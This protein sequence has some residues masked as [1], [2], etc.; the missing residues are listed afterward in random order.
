MLADLEMS[1]ASCPLPFSAFFGIGRWRCPTLPAAAATAPSASPSPGTPP[2]P[3][4]KRSTQIA[5]L[6]LE[7]LDALP[8]FLLCDPGVR[9]Q[10]FG[11]RAERVNPFGVPAPLRNARQQFGITR[12]Q[13][14]ELLAF[15]YLL[16]RH[17]RRLDDLFS[18][19]MRQLLERL[20]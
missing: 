18:L 16:D 11:L 19:G 8:H 2:P 12:A 7:R 10:R 17:R 6:R 14:C 20:G 9:V 5:N 15:Y 3:Q 1:I 4:P 13:A